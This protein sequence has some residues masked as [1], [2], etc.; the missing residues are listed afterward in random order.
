MSDVAIRGYRPEDLE[1]C[2][3]MWVVLTDWHRGIY[4]SPDIGGDD[5]GCHFDKHLSAVGP[6]NLWVAEADGRVVGL[7]GMIPGD[8]EAELEPLVIRKEWRGRGIG[9]RLA[10]RVVAAARETRVKSLKVRPVG[11]NEDAIRAFH[12]MGFGILGHIEMFM[13]FR[14]HKPGAWREGERIG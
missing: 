13:D 5:P 11:R 8:G 6:E 4:E 9:R 7:T 10:E 14:E 1:S 2:R 3:E 12:A